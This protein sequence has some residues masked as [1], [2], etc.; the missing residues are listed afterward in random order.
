MKEGFY[1]WFYWKLNWVKLN[2]FLHCQ[3]ASNIYIILPVKTWNLYQEK[4]KLITDK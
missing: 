3:I 1:N 2:E 4:N